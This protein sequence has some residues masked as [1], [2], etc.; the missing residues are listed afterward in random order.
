MSFKN[1]LFL[2]LQENTF[3]NFYIINI[4][5]LFY[6]FIVV[7][8]NILEIKDIYIDLQF[9]KIFKKDNFNN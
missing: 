4:K 7:C 9:I 3:I 5:T 6:L 8:K 1:F 2:I